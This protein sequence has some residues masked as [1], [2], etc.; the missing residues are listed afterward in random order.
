MSMDILKP[1]LAYD[2][3]KLS[4]GRAVPLMFPFIAQ[5]K[6]DGFRCIIFNGYAYSRA[7]QLFKNP[8]VVAIAK[9]IKENYPTLNYPL[10]GELTVGTPTNPHV[11]NATQ[12]LNGLEPIEDVRFNC[13]DV[14]VPGEPQHKRITFL[15]EYFRDD[16]RDIGVML[17]IY[18]HIPDENSLWA[19]Y[20]LLI[21]HGYEGI[22][23]P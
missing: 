16:P 13:F 14:I 22:I 18:E 4:E 23:S 21:S 2:L 3:E 5:P 19:Y 9:A 10:D 1:M 15:M 11:Y 20:N 7:G 6:M 8:S 12:S 17:P